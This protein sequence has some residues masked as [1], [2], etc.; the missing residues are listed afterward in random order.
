L[1]AL[2]SISA[3]TWPRKKFRC[4]EDFMETA[5]VIALLGIVG[6]LLGSLGGRDRR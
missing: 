4:T 6:T 1:A 3:V 2:Y 5:T